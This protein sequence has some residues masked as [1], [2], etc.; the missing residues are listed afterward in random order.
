MPPPFPALKRSRKRIPFQS[1]QPFNRY[2][3][4]KSFRERK[5]GTLKFGNSRRVDGGRKPLRLAVEKVKSE[6]GIKSCIG[7]GIYALRESSQAYGDEFAQES[8]ALTPENTIPWQ[9]FNETAATYHRMGD[10]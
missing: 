4:F 3:Q 9:K 8:E 2:A 1:F 7:S 6:L 10:P 5:R